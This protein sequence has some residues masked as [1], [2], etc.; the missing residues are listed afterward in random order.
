M[1]ELDVT[2]HLFGSPLHLQFRNAP[3]AILIL[4]SV[5]SLAVMLHFTATSAVVQRCTY[6]NLLAIHQVVFPASFMASTTCQSGCRAMRASAYAW[7]SVLA[8]GLVLM[9]LIVLTKR[10]RESWSVVGVFDQRTC[11]WLQSK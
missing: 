2:V 5:M 4:H 6:S 8:A 1:P 10:P 9:L 11:S 7:T 3:A